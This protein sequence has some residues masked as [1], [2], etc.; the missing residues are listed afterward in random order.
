VNFVATPLPG[1]YLVELDP[2][3]DERGFFSRAYCEHE[4]AAQGLA[5]RYPQWNL[6]RNDA[7]GTLRGLH[8][9]RPPHA[10]VKIVRCVAGEIW[11]VIVDLRR[12]SPAWRKWFGVELTARAGTALYVPAGFAHG[13]ITLQPDT[14]VLYQMGEFHAPAAAVGFR[15]DDPAIGIHWPLRPVVISERD[16]S[17]PDFDPLLLDG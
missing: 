17:Y 11:D 13:F 12:S 7:R 8:M 10:E 3:R 9:Q 1:A 2:H 4:F 14:D 16:R 6:S 5:T 15:W